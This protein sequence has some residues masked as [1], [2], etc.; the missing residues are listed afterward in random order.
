MTEEEFFNKR[1]IFDIYLLITTNIQE[2]TIKE[3]FK[4]ETHKKW[5]TYS[6]INVYIGWILQTML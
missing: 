3:K 5:F 1:L 6:R 4:S 2:K